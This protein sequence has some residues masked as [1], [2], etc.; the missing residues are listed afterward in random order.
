MFE[1]E[2]KFNVETHAGVEGQL[3]ELGARFAEPIEQ[4]D[5]YFAHPQRD[6]ASTDEALR[7]R[8]VGD[9]NYITYKGPKIDTATKTRR[10]IEL[11]LRSGT[12]HAEQFAELLQALGF[13]PVASVRKIRRSAAL[14]YQDWDFEVALDEVTSLGTFVELELAADSSQLDAAR[15]RLHTLAAQLNLTNVERRSYLELLLEADPQT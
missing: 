12:E 14:R 10:E 3:R 9:E 11:P 1:V 5:R 7:I 8:C 4:V 15:E 13:E 2:Q 6:F